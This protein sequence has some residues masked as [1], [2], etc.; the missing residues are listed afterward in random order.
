MLS[1]KVTQFTLIFM[2]KIDL[3]PLRPGDAIWRHG[4]LSSLAQ[5]MPWRRIGSCANADLLSEEYVETKT[6][7]ISSNIA[8]FGHAS[9]REVRF[10]K[11]ANHLCCGNQFP[12][13]S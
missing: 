4:F 2:G 1:T 6:I 7:I 12:T 8:C 10:E 13:A 5:L 9:G 11:L 3:N